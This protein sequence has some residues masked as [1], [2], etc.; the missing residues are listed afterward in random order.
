PSPMVRRPLQKSGTAVPPSGPGSPSSARSSPAYPSFAVP[1]PPRPARVSFAGAGS[2]WRVPS[3]AEVAHEAAALLIQ[4]ALP[5][6]GRLHPALPGGPPVLPEEWHGSASGRDGWGEGAGLVA[7]GTRHP[8]R[9]LGVQ[10]PATGTTAG[11]RRG[12]GGN[13][14]GHPAGRRCRLRECCA[15]VAAAVF[16][17]AAGRC[18]L[19]PEEP[20]A[21][22]PAPRP[23][24]HVALFMGSA[25]FPRR[26]R[27][28]LLSGLHNRAGGNLKRCC[29]AGSPAAP[30]TSARPPLPQDTVVPERGPALGKLVP[31]S[32]AAPGL[33][34]V[35]GSGRSGV[36][37]PAWW[38]WGAGPAPLLPRNCQDRPPQPDQPPRPSAQ[39]WPAPRSP[40]ESRG[41]SLL[42]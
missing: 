26:L 3:P 17:P 23:G 28:T 30:G 31:G 32:P 21:L 14:A 15:A 6:V 18:S 40:A 12:G 20:P 34:E 33:N 42:T 1:A 19:L 10:G 36:W 8:G 22:S 39:L 35:Q 27:L 9:M 16:M 29:Q 11:N 24:G 13:G 25:C 7:S 41:R 2:W 37:V 5:A 38:A 4:E